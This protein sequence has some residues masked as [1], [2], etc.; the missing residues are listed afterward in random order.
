LCEALEEDKNDVN[1]GVEDGARVCAAWDG[2][3]GKEGIVVERTTYGQYGRCSLSRSNCRAFGGSAVLGPF[4][5]ARFIRGVE[6][7]AQSPSRLWHKEQCKSDVSL[8]RSG[9][10]LGGLKRLGVSSNNARWVGVLVRVVLLCLTGRR[11]V[12]GSGSADEISAGETEDAR[13]VYGERLVD[14]GDGCAEATRDQPNND[15]RMALEDGTGRVDSCWIDDSS[16][17]GFSGP[18]FSLAGDSAPTE[19]ITDRKD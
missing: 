6:M 18:T 14:W 15:E 17:A 12:R 2:A 10:T 4:S 11:G 9:D 1:E 13:D 19:A 8:R 16:S 5:D 3:T 7:I